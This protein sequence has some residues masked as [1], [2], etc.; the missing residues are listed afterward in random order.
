MERKLKAT[1]IAVLDSCIEAMNDSNQTI[2]AAQMAG[3]QALSAYR[4]QFS[5]IALRLK[6]DFETHSA[7]YIAERGVIELTKLEDEDE[8]KAKAKGEE[9]APET[10]SDSQDPDEAE[11]V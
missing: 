3:Q 4:K 2:R 10:L 6:I 11:K 5:K 8:E 1:D 9:E 7:D